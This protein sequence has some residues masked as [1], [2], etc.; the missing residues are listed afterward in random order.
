MIFIQLKALSS[1]YDGMDI[2]S[3]SEFNSLAIKCLFMSLSVP[4][5]VVSLT[6]KPMILFAK[7]CRTKPWIGP[8]LREGTLSAWNIFSLPDFKT[9][10]TSAQVGALLDE[11]TLVNKTWRRPF[12]LTLPVKSSCSSLQNKQHFPQS[13]FSPSIRRSK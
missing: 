2:P 9:L 13:H 11:K 5:F 1:K 7:S 10:M 12:L 4:T 6:V 8:V 3:S